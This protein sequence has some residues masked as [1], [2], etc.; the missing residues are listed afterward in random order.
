MCIT[1]GEIL[2]A[3][4]IQ[5]KNERAV[6]AQK[7]L[8]KSI[9]ENKKFRDAHKVNLKRL[10]GEQLMVSDLNS[11]IKYVLAVSGSSDKPSQYSTEA[12]IKVRLTELDK[13]W[14]S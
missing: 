1:A 10:K 8:K 9:I 5:L 12:L 11:V 6:W 4:R 3:Q 13:D 14:Q 2:K 7:E